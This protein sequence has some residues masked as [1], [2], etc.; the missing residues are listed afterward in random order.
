MGKRT[1]NP[2]KAYAPIA[3]QGD[4]KGLDDKSGK[5][6]SLFYIDMGRFM[7]QEQSKLLANFVKSVLEDAGIDVDLFNHSESHQ[8]YVKER[9]KS[10]EVRI[11]D[12][13][14]LGV[15]YNMF[16]SQK[17]THYDIQVRWTFEDNQ[18]MLN[19]KG[20]KNGVTWNG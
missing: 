10:K 20:M 15:D 16:D 9:I 8:K 1:K 18:L 7:I 11:N 13:Q 19:Y 17:L 12:G 2:Y 5:D 4:V 14:V 3:L 6:E